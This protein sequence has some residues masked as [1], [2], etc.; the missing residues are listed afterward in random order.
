MVIK[1]WTKYSPLRI[2]V[3]GDDLYSRQ[4]LCQMLLEQKCNF[5]LV[6]RPESHQTLYEHLEGI[7]LPTVITTRWTG[8][9]TETSTYRYLNQVPLKNEDEALLVNSAILIMGISL[10]QRVDP[11]QFN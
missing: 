7:K 5:I 6:C 2:T 4:P 3:L 11:W 1:A 10:V 8:K 9:L